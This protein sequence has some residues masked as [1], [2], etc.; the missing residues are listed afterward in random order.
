MT[1]FYLLKNQ[2]NHAVINNLSLR[3]NYLV[4]N[5]FISIKLHSIAKHF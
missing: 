3:D 4:E 2:L 5:A 1:S